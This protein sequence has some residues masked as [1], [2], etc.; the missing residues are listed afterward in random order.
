LTASFNLALAFA[1]GL[2]TIVS[3]CVLPL[4]PIVVVGARAENPFGPLALAGGLAVTFGVLG[5]ALAALGVELGETGGIRMASAVAMLLVGLAMVVPGS[6][7]YTERLFSPLARL[8]DRLALHLPD[9]GLAGQA[10]IGAVLALAWAPCVG[11]TLGAALALAAS[12]G[13][14]PAS[15][16]TMTIFALGTT[17][18]LLLVGYG[19]EKVAAAGRRLAG[20]TAQLGRAALGIVFAL[21]G[22]AILTGFDRHLE[23]AAIGIMPNWLVTVATRL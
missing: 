7:A 4:A 5:G 12:G 19:L 2:L 17:T 20:R 23:T 3:P 15:M 14:L 13:S 16:L 22:A 11:P 1:A 21:V 10:A 9:S 8:S 18:A 6:A